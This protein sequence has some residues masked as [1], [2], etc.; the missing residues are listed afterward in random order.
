M[1]ESAVLAEELFVVLLPAGGVLER[2]AYLQKQIADTFQVYKEGYYPQLHIT[3]DRIKK[4]HLAE[5]KKVI[6]N[7]VKKSKVVELGLDSFSCFNKS[8]NNFLVLKLKE[9]KSLR[10]F[11]VDLHEGL[12]KRGISSLKN[13]REWEF[14]ITIISN[15]FARRPIPELDFNELC[16]YLE[17]QGDQTYTGWADTLEVW[18]PVPDSEEKCLLSYKLDD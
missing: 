7:F 17:G 8:E 15:L 16:Y 12:A 14:H 3:I 10:G 1:I 2:T 13:Y 18:S 4:D 9:T 11:A 6:D 5:A